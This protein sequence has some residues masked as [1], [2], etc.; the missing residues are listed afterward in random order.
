MYRLIAKN[1]HNS[2]LRVF[3]GQD[4]FMSQT[5]GCQLFF[6]SYIDIVKI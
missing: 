4:F 3:T 2:K 6:T 5:D 1:Y